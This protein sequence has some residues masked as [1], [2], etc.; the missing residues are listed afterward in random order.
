METVN[1]VELEEA[2]RLLGECMLFRGLRAEERN[3]LVARAHVR[4]LPAGE[5]IF[6]MDDAGDSMMAVLD[7][8]G[9]TADARA[10]TECSL[11]VLDRREVLSFFERHPQAW[12][13]LV[14]VLCERLRVT[15]QH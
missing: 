10:L 13:R 8:K 6:M 15:D 11:A 1:R 14:E 12:L 5:N 9:R 2:R 7:G 4:K 3:S